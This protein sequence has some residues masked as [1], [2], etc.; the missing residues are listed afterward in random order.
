[1]MAVDAHL[2]GEDTSRAGVLLRDI[3]MERPIIVQSGNGTH[4]PFAALH[5]FGSY[6][7]VF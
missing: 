2:A 6:R 7:G 5:K 4:S 1:M 3:S